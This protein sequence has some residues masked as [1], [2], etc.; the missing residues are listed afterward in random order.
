MELMYIN[1]VWVVLAAAMVLFMEGGFSLLEAGFVR[2]KNAVNVTMKIFVDH[3][4]FSFLAH[5]LRDY[6]WKRCLWIHR[7]KPFWKS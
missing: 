1:T 7:D 2:T 5:R 6:V 3:W 4:S